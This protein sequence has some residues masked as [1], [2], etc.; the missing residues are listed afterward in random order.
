MS[1]GHSVADIAFH[2]TTSQKSEVDPVSVLENT[3][4]PDVF[5]NDPVPVSMLAEQSGGAS[6][7]V[8]DPTTCAVMAEG[9]RG[10]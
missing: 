7:T 1:P 2:G 8:F 4:T 5:I 6:Q 10:T 3:S 9:E